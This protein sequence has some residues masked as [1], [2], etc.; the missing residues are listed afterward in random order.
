MAG[1]CVRTSIYTGAS[2]CFSLVLLTLTRNSF[3]ERLISK[4][5]SYITAAIVFLFTSKYPVPKSSETIRP[6]HDIMPSLTSAPAKTAVA[7]D[8]GI[9]KKPLVPQVTNGSTAS[10]T[11]PQSKNVKVGVWN[12]NST[13]FTELE[14][15]E[16]TESLFSGTA[17]ESVLGEDSRK[18]VDKK[19]LMP[20][21][22]YRRKS[23]EQSLL[24]GKKAF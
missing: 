16:N 22:K 19:D 21:G 10:H 5:Q 24:F 6:S 8:S 23:S 11:T 18:R 20:G 2:S 9:V 15:P 3:E 7:K 12:L 13:E 17:G 14:A 4:A 1:S